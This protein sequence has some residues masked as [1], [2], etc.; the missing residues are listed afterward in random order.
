MAPRIKANAIIEL[1]GYFFVGCQLLYVLF[2][3]FVVVNL[4]SCRLV[5][6][7]DYK[8][9]VRVSTIGMHI[10]ICTAKLLIERIISLVQWRCTHSQL[11]VL[12][13]KRIYLNWCVKRINL[14]RICGLA[15]L[16]LTMHHFLFK[17][18]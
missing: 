18:S 2:Q 3:L 9:G 16:L 12:L 10:T 15:Y 13:G 14:S 4:P 1:F 6:V 7:C 5:P 8:S 11:L 17:H